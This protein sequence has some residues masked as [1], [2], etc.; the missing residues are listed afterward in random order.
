MVVRPIQPSDAAELRRA[1]RALSPE[2]RYR[3]FFG[4]I[5]DLDDKALE[6]LTHVDGRDHVALV[7]TTES[8]D[9]KR[10]IGVGVARFVRSKTDDK[11]AEAA[12]TVVDDMQRQGVGTMLSRALVAAARERGIER[13]RCEVLES[14]D[15]VVRALLDAGAVVVDRGEGAVVLDV[16]L[17][18][19]EPESAV[20]RA[21]RFA[22][23]H[24]NTF[25]RRLGPP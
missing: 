23:E 1:F 22:A 24:V 4:A 3:R 14:N 13:F 12:V 2:T 19:L 9:L 7:A 18:D 8:L 6:Y 15:V 21:L 17:A 20:R 25:L 16:P 5:T 11:V 10:E